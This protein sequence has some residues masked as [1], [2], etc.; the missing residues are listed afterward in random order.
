MQAYNIIQLG[1]YLN[2]AAMYT[3]RDQFVISFTHTCCRKIP[4]IQSPNIAEYNRVQLRAIDNFG[5]SQWLCLRFRNYF[6]QIHFLLFFFD[7]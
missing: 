2:L 1:W 7:I 5:E 4:K 3:E 6:F